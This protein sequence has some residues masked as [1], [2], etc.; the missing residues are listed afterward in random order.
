MVLQCVDFARQFLDA[1]ERHDADF[2]IFE[3][4]GIAGVVVIHNTVQT[5]DFAGHLKARD[6]V[7]PVLRR[8]AGLEEACAYG[9]QRGELLAIAKQRGASLD[10][11]PY[12]HHIIDALELIVVQAHRHAQFTQ[13]AVGARHLEC[14]RRHMNRNLPGFRQSARR[15]VGVG[16]GD[17]GDAGWG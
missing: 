9:K 11:A 7:A 8:H 6:L 16:F 4:H 12:R 15:H 14:L 13:I 5:D 2:S 3:R 10:L 17:D 1:V